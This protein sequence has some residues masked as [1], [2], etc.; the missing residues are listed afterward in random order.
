MCPFFFLVTCSF[1]KYDNFPDL[2]VLQEENTAYT[3]A[4]GMSAKCDYRGG[5]IQEVK[6][7][8]HEENDAVLHVSRACLLKVVTGTVM[9]TTDIK[10][11]GCGNKIRLISKLAAVFFM[12][13]LD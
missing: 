4:G 8:W 12:Y 5:C 2:R 7:K 10:L 11:C 6:L 9:N 1:H 13:I 3:A